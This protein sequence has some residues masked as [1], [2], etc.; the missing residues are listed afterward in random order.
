MLTAQLGPDRSAAA[1]VSGQIE[2]VARADRALAGEMD[3]IGACRAPVCTETVLQL[4]SLL[5]DLRDAAR[6]RTDL[7]RVDPELLQAGAALWAGQSTAAPGGRS[8][9]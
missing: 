8:V 9:R 4:E 3:R 5:V 7:A 2:L 1:E 6:V